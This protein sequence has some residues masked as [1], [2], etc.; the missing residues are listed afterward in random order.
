MT[1]AHR[2][3][4]CAACAKA[5]RATH[6]TPGH[7]C[8]SCI[9]R[10]HRRAHF[11]GLSVDAS[12]RSLHPCQSAFCL[13]A[14]TNKALPARRMCTTGQPGQDW[15]D[16]VRHSKKSNIKTQ[17]PF[18]AKASVRNSR[19]S[20]TP[21]PPAASISNSRSC[22][23]RNKALCKISSSPKC[24]AHLFLGDRTARQLAK[25]WELLT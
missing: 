6:G 15:V 17:F 2:A 7:F 8:C 19:S 24:P 25:G 10:N 1:A 9:P 18:Y 16:F 11:H 13:R 20:P 12:A 3:F 4:R 22:T 23:C 21:V 5:I 14:D